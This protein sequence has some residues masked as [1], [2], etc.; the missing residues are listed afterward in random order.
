MKMESDRMV[1]LTLTREN[2]E[3]EKKVILEERFQRVESSPS[4][5]LDESMRSILF[6]NHYYGRPIIGW[7]HEIENLNFEDIIEFYKQYYVPNNATLVLSGD[8][9]FESIKKLSKK[10]FGK[11]KKGKPLIYKNVVDPKWRHL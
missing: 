5:K 1:N 4:A 8:V 7:K 11:K 6:P 9:D 10:Y 2:V 3:T